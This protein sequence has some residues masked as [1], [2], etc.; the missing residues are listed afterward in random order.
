MLYIGSFFIL[1]GLYSICDEFY[2]FK[3][4]LKEKILIKK[5]N[6]E[7]DNFAKI[8]ML[9]GLFCIVV[10]TYSLINYFYY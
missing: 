3:V 4:F 5:E 10:G 9:N 2:D 6:V 7:I 1:L 8:K